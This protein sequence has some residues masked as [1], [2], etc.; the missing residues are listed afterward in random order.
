MSGS[1]WH[2]KRFTYLALKVLDAEVEFFHQKLTDYINFEAEAD[3]VEDVGDE[4]SDFSDTESEN[5]FIDYQ[6]VNTVTNFYR[7]FANV[8]NDIE[9]VLQDSY[10]EGLEDIENF[11]K[12]SN[13]CEGSK[14]EFEIDN[15]KNF[16]VDI[17]KSKETLFPRVDVEDQKVHNQFSCAILYVLQ[18]DK[19]G[20]KDKYDKQEF[21]KSIDQSLIQKLIDK[22]EFI[23]DLQ[24]FHNMCMKSILFCR[25][26]IIFRKNIFKNYVLKKFFKQTIIQ[27]SY[28]LIEVALD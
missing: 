11:D 3:F 22:F 27:L 21:E 7:L 8:Q 20:F 17:E 28:C 12:I 5:S 25:N 15:F 24:K 18:F 6:D 1:A 10:D 16:E 2:S 4:V 19:T 14:D 13:L 9:Q 23:T 26:A